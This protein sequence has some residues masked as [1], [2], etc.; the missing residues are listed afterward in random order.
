MTTMGFD[1]E[2]RIKKVKQFIDR[3]NLDYVIVTN[4]QNLYWLTGT[5]QYGSLLLKAEDDPKLFVRRNFFRAK[6]ESIVNDIVELKKTSQIT[7]HIINCSPNIEHPKIG[8]EL[9]S[10][11][12]SYYQYYKKLLNQAEILN[13]EMKLRKL[14]MI[15]DQ[16]EIEIHKKAG[17]VAQK[18][19]EKLA[20]ILKPG[21][22][23]HEIAAEVMKEA[24][25]NKSVHFSNVNNAFGR[26]WFILT[27]GD[28][29][30]TP[31]SFPIL[32]GNGFSPAIPYGYSDRKFQD[33]DMV[34]CDFAIIYEGY[35]ADHARTFHAGTVPEKFKENYLILK[36]T[37]LGVIEDYLRAGNPV[38]IIYKKMKTLLEKENLDKYFQG[39]GYYYQGLGHGI[40]LEL[41]EPPYFLPN[42]DTILKENMVVSLEPKIIIPHW[43]AINLEDNFV[44]K[45]G[46]PQQLT[47]TEYLF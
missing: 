43:G 29:L 5:A 16:K 9:D 12:T 24:I 10:L 22:R 13:V 40:G 20:G 35:H 27:S 23:E 19:Q 32:S 30:W 26:N 7:D 6:K 31:S 2:S 15:K 34:V 46:K 25:K 33:G 3:K 8:M 47:N 44:I 17:E 14:R 18:T 28:G 11:P 39:D 36:D 4:L 45:R 37:F 42:N 38:N 1:Y 21:L 41:D